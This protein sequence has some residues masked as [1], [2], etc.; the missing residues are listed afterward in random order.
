[1]NLTYEDV[2]ALIDALKAAHP[3]AFSTVER[4]LI[5]VRWSKDRL[6]LVIVVH[7]ACPARQF[8][9]LPGRFRG[10]P[11]HIDYMPEEGY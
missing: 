8:V 6:A 5:G 1:V 4:Y 10:Y 11:I 3:E 2:G 9:P 7:D